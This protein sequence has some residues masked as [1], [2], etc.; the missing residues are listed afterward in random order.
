M[1]SL[2]LALHFVVP[3]LVGVA[4]YRRRWRQAVLIL[5]ATM[6]VDLDHLLATP[7]YDPERCSIGIHPLH[8]AL[9]IAIYVALFAVP[10]V[11]DRKAGARGMRPALRTIHLIG[12][13]LL[14]HMALD[15]TDCLV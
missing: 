3:L 9:P 6:L 11:L 13:G 7:V 1:S 10:L 5:M 2:H 14:I 4:F 15:W 8:G 12:L